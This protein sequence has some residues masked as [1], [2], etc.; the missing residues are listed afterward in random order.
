MNL[1]SILKMGK[2]LN[3]MGFL[4]GFFPYKEVFPNLTL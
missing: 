1:D 3:F 4:T 2:A